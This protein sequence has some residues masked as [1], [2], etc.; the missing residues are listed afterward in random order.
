MPA[1]RARADV[2]FEIRGQFLLLQGRSSDKSPEKARAGCPTSEFE[3]LLG[4]DLQVSSRIASDRKAQTA[5]DQAGLVWKFIIASHCPGTQ[6]TMHLLLVSPAG[7]TT[8]R[9]PPPFT[10]LVVLALDVC[11]DRSKVTPKPTRSLR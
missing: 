10:C 3:G 11:A 1:V 7:N 2:Q 9:G 5:P 6:C 8:V 4:F